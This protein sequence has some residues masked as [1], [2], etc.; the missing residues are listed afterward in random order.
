MDW[1]LLMFPQGGLECAEYI[2]QR[3]KL[4]FCSLFPSAK[5]PSPSLTVSRQF[6][7]LSITLLLTMSWLSTSSSVKFT[8]QSFR[9]A[10]ILKFFWG[11]PLTQI[12]AYATIRRNTADHSEWRT[13]IFASKNGRCVFNHLVYHSSEYD[14]QSLAAYKYLLHIVHILMLHFI[15]WTEISIITYI[16][17]TSYCWH[18]Y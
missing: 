10:A 4:H 14:K 11:L 9:T 2:A 8:F 12:N 3:K 15:C 18:I 13:S 1:R 5:A 17:R 7:G 6:A 16:F